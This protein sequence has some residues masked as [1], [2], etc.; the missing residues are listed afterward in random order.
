[1]NNFTVIYKNNGAALIT[2]LMLLVVMTILGVSSIT[3]STMEERMAGNILNKHM[4]F[5]AAEAALRAG[6]TIAANL[7]GDTI[8]TDPTTPAS[9]ADGLYDRSEALDANFPV[10]EDATATWQDATTAGSIVIQNPQYIIE[11]YSNAPRD[12][13]CVLEVPLPAGCMLPV[14]RVTARGWGLNTNG[15][16]IVQSTYKQL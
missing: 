11:K 8:Y 10:W 4:S 15:F 14:F 1:M 7:P 6:E 16:S 2:C 5:Q 9:S 13:D 12:A 3:S